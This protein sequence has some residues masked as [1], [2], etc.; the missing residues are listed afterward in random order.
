[1]ARA[2]GTR[3]LSAC[4]AMV[5]WRLCDFAIPVAKSH[6]HRES[7]LLL[8]CPS[9]LLELLQFFADAI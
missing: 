1:M 4:T 2:D 9:E 5:V 8:R 6:S 7:S 3:Y